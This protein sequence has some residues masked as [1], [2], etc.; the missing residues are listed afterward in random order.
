[1]KRIETGFIVLVLFA[2]VIIAVMVGDALFQGV[3][4]P[5]TGGL[6]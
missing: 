6:Q 1:M 3:I 5:I 2:L 4:I